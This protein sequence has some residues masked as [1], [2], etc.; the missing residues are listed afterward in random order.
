M[1]WLENLAKACGVIAA[2]FLCLIGILVTAQIISRMMGKMIPSSDE[3]AAWAMASSIFL[4]LPYTMLRGEHIRVTLI[5]QFLPKGLHKPYELLATLLALCFSIWMSYYV[6][7]FVYESY[8]FNDVSQGIVTVPMW[9]PQFGM[10]I[11][12]CIF[13]LMLLRRLVCCLRN[14]PLE[15]N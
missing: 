7:E 13:T 8:L 14:Q 5:L 3:F 9:I 15:D 11:G 1:K 6:V 4:A 10:P 12:L 2:C